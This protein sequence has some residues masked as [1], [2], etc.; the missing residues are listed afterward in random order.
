[1]G[2]S[3]GER[4]LYRVLDI[5]ERFSRGDVISKEK[6]A[7]I[8]D[9]NEKSIQRDIADLNKHFSYNDTDI[10]RK[11]EY[12]QQK[13]GYQMINRNSFKFTN[14][15]VFAVAKIILESR[16]FSNNEMN[17]ILDLLMCQVND[18]DVIKKLIS[19]EIFHYVQPK[20]GIDIVDFIWQ[21][22]ISINE[23]KIV[24]AKY[25]RQDGITKEHTLKP[26][27][28]VFNEY[29]FYLIAEKADGSNNYQVVFRI[30]RF[31]EYIITDNKFL[32][33]YRDRFEEGEFHKRIQFMYTGELVKIQFN[34][35]GNSVEAI[36]DRLP[37]AKVIE[38]CENKTVIQAEVYWDGVKRWLLSQQELLEVVSPE[39]YRNDI[40]E[41]LKKMW[42]NYK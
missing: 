17:R 3:T 7:Q 29:Y 39:Q 4:K 31:I 23:K 22:S 27:G 32:V 21:I 42:E 6:L 37:T 38:E 5:Y 2:N 11:I 26:L 16:A 1:M 35:Y 33:P 18:K 10:K 36:L 13:S 8:Y 34:F 14:S 25:R 20:H 40:R 15:D 28:L 30:D 12:K 24:K 9:V 19:N 41:I